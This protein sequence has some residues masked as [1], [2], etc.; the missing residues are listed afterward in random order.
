[1]VVSVTTKVLVGHSV[2]HGVAAGDGEVSLDPLLVL[3]VGGRREAAR[4]GVNA[5][6]G[7]LH[8]LDVAFHFVT[9]PSEV[10]DPT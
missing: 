10:H 7:K 2:G 6:L 9:L 1:M 5:V 4:G 3:E 8:L